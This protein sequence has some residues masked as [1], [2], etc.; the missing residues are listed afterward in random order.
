MK[1]LWKIFVRV[2]RS[3]S[4]E[5]KVITIIVFGIVVFV[6]AQ[7]IV[8]VFKRPNVFT[9]D[10]RSFTEG[11]VSDRPVIINPL[12]VDFNDSGRDIS[13]LVF[14]GLSKYDPA[15]HA[16]VDD[17]ATLAI[18]EDKMTY[19]YTLKP[20]ILWQDGQPVTA[21]DVYFTYHDIIQSP[22]FQNPVIKVDFD[23]VDI[24]E[25]NSKTIEFKLK[26]P[27]AFFITNMNVGILPKHLLADT[28]VSEL[29]T[30]QF[31]VKPVGTGPYMVD[32]PVEIFDD[33]REKVSLKAFEN[34][35]G[36][37]PQI[38][39]IHFNIYPNFDN[40]LD[41]IG[42]VNII[43]KVPTANLGDVQKTG[44]FSLMNYELPQ[45]T[46]VFFNMDN[47]ALKKDK[48]RVG[49]LKA[50][51]KQQLLKQFSDKIAVDT[52]LLELN[53]EDWI[54]KPSLEEAQGA[55]YDAGYKIDKTKDQP[56]RVD[57]DGKQLSF[58][59]LARAY[60]E[61]T[62]LADE[63]QKT[64]QFLKD[65]WA[66]LGIAIDVQMVDGDTYLKRLQARDYDMALVGQSLGY[67]LDTYSYW[68]STQATAK[69]LNLSNYKSFAADQLIEKIRDTFDPTV[70]ADDLKQLAKVIADDVPAVFLYRP[71]YT[72]A[73]DN[74]V[75]GLT[76]DNL[77]FPSD[78]FA[79]IAKWCVVC[80]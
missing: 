1:R 8:D 54:Y 2:L 71:K 11:M 66:Q 39:Q 26:K 47:E 78:R 40:L 80:Q 9:M 61:G 52:P 10:G 15:N 51:D 16:F 77:A 68:H 22:D 32:A 56:F 23:G 48:V 24:K 34:F 41:E 53:Q 30:S 60:D 18:S 65:Q 5:E 35:Y 21:D 7:A 33:G 20:N 13:S 62:A 76:L 70:K 50:V 6:L 38:N 64:V 45:Y 29:P 19:S 59:L 36:N 63:T 17:M 67:N 28:P 14:S 44:R 57:K 58:T 4:V 55:M 42:T 74:K 43:A 25:V 75:H 79:G 72:L 27:N 37:R 69:G 73:T 46:A 3:Y 49:L 12:Y 31:N